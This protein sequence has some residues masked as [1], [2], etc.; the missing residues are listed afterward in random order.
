VRQRELQREINTGLNVVESW[1]RDNSVIF[2]GK[3]GDI[4]TNRRDEQELAMACLRILQAAQVNSTMSQNARARSGM[5]RNRALATIMV[6]AMVIVI[7]TYGSRG[8]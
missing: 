7:A 8:T 5:T 3:D 6:V 2:Y 1:N 4:A